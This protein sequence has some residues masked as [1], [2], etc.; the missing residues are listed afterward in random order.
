M[1]SAATPVLN[2]GRTARRADRIAAVAIV[3]HGG[4]E[5]SHAPTSP[6]SPSVLRLRPIVWCLR[7]R[8]REHSLAVW[9]LRF[10]VRGWNGDEMS[11]MADV[12]WALEEVRSRHGDVPVALV[13]HSMGG[14]AAL[15]A[16][17]GQVRSIVA[18]AP[19]LPAGEPVDQLA[20]CSVLI[21]H[22][23]K[24]RR[25]SPRRSREFAD[26]AAAVAE[27]VSWVEVRGS[28]HAMVQRA[29]RWHR[30]TT[31]FVLGSL[32]FVTLSAP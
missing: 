12:C 23:N 4:T 10:A 21:A 30:L 18:L 31:D 7:R 16:G 25:T 11:P 32:G 22:G 2:V 27:H 20:G 14:R 19:W 28:G 1:S 15:R 17:G 8:G 24:D 9:S 29:R 13:G 5:W 26:E 3:L 6:W